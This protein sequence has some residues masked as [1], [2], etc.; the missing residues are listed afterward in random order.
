VKKIE[1]LMPEQEAEL[2][3]F[4]QRYLDIACKGG[5]IDR[6]A[7]Q[8]ALTDVYAVIGKPAPKLFIFDSPA[9]CM[10]ALKI[11]EMPPRGKLKDQIWDQLRGQ[12]DG[13]IW[14]Q[15]VDQLGDQLVDQLR[16]KLWDQLR[17]QLEGQLRGQ[18]KDQIWGKL[19]DQIGNQLWDQ[20]WG[21]IGNQL[22]G[23][24]WDQLRDQ[25]WGKLWDQLVDQLVDQLGDQLRGKLWDQLVDQLGD[26]IW[27][28]KIYDPHYLWGSQDL[29]WIAWAKF[30]NKIGV[31]FTADQSHKLDI[32]ERI[33]TQCEWWW[34]CEN[35]VIA[36]ERPIH[37]RWDDERR[38]HGENG[39]AVEYADGYG[40]AAWHGQRIP[41]AWVTGNPPSAAEALRWDNLDQRSAACE[42]VGWHK[43][44]DVLDARLID[45]S[46]DH[47]WGRLVEVDLPDNGPQRMLDA[48]CG[49]GRRFALLVPNHVRTVDQAQS[50]LHGDIP[51]DILRNGVVRT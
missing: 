43:I 42:I 20:L 15:L 11:F 38:L 49:T 50:V 21:Q 30:A 5:R 14:D 32:M 19:K 18:L 31:N 26:Q 29:Y 1:K 2:P 40:L 17:G 46:G 35:I 44:M 51:A 48:M 39:L 12:L 9:A 23:Q 13:Q 16:G 6:D 34:P 33:G 45:D 3:L 41:E 36:S 10:L 24:L 4:R 25:L 8:V 7:L 47:A 37:V 22:G 28:Q 27:G